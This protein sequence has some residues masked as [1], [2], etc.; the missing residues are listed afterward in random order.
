MGV[1][2]MIPVI[3][4]SMV[5]CGTPFSKT[6]ST[7][8]D[9]STWNTVFEAGW[10]HMFFGLAVLALVQ[11]W[12]SL[13]SYVN[14]RWHLTTVAPLWDAEIV[15]WP[16]E[17]APGPGICGSWRTGTSCQGSAG[18]CTG[19]MVVHAT[20]LQGSTMIT[21]TC[22]QAY[23]KH[24]Y[25]KPDKAPFCFLRVFAS[26]C[27]ARF[28]FVSV[29]S[30]KMVRTV[31][32]APGGTE[33]PKPRST[34][35]NGEVWLGWYIAASTLSE[36]PPPS[37]K[38]STLDKECGKSPVIFYC[39]VRGPGECT[40][41]VV[42]PDQFGINGSSTM[43]APLIMARLNDHQLSSSHAALW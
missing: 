6:I 27:Q 33:I 7:W 23:I 2:Q 14:V 42:V 28:G 34:S 18:R 19:L 40:G 12:R 3:R 17:I 31:W 9:V 37:L 11:R 1:P 4:P 21:R 26:A 36:E 30:T 38:P 39:R 41:E 43:A 16:A 22:G 13:S 35:F 10:N 15:K 25:S 8:D 20:M 24:T 5:T 32:I 29:V